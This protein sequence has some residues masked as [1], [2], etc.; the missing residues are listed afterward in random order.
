MSVESAA[1]AKPALGR[2]RRVVLFLE[3]YGTLIGM[4]LVF[5]IIGLLEPRFLTMGNFLN[6]LRQAATLTLVALGLTFV[7]AAG[8][9]DISVGGV[10]G[11]CSIVA[12][13]VLAR[14]YGFVLASLAALLTGLSVGFVNGLL[15]AR[16]H[17]NDFLATVAMMARSIPTFQRTAATPRGLSAPR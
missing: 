4:I 11:L 17:T 8:V 5:P 9:F 6:I 10:A 7:L 3:N 1:V 12:A 14:G 15:V 2:G 13:L 16:F